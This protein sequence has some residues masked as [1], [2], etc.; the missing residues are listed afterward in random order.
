MHDF[1]V[2][3]WDSVTD[4]IIEHALWGAGMNLR[5]NG[6]MGIPIRVR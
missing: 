2:R 5:I 6:Q 4:C 3:G 1:P